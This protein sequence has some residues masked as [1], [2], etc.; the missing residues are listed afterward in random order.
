MKPTMVLRVAKTQGYYEIAEYVVDDGENQE[1]YT[2]QQRLKHMGIHPG[3][4]ISGLTMTGSARVQRVMPTMR[5][6]DFETR[7]CRIDFEV[8]HNTPSTPFR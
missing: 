5:R 3:D 2:A 1:L 4:T 6:D 8:Y 7:V